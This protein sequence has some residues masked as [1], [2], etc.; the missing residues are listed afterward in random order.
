MFNAE[1]IVNLLQKKINENN[2]LLN[3]PMKKH[4]TFKIGGN[5]DIF[6]KVNDIEQIKYVLQIVKENEIPLF[7]LGNGSN[8]LVKDE[9]IRGIVL[10]IELNEIQIL[11]ESNK[12]KV[13]VSSGVKLS[14]LAQKLYKNSIKGFE[15]ASGIPGTIGGAIRM[16]A[17]AYGNEMKDIVL[18]TTYIDFNGKIHT[19]SNEEHNFEY[20]NS[21]FSNEKVIILSTTLML[22]KGNINEIKEKMDNYNEQRKE[23]QPLEYSNA[24]STFKRG[25]DYITSILIDKCGLKGK[26]IGKAEVSEKHAGFIVNT[27]DASFEDVMNLINLVKKEVYEKFNKKLE[28]EIEIVG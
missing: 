11:E 27:G 19:I 13:I 24:G 9:G 25:E 21:R 4:T 3:E 7:I 16:N 5:A 28:L 18:E 10:K 6:V 15:F 22:E 8:I 26:K 12:V 1:K 14:Q 23:K 17:G 2:I 20:R